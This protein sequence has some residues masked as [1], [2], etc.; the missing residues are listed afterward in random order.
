MQNLKQK[1][2]RR[3]DIGPNF[4]KCLTVFGSQQEMSRAI[5]IPDSSINHIL[6]GRP[7]LRDKTIKRYEGLCRAYLDK[8]DKQP[9]PEPEP[10]K[11][12]QAALDLDQKKVFLVSVLP[13]KAD[14]LK[15]IMAMFG[16]QIG[17]VD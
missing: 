2:P 11:P 13:G 1:Y 16:A 9:E 17:E 4:E 10:D 12:T 7:L 5:F 6:N 3:C 8:I 14:K 15:A